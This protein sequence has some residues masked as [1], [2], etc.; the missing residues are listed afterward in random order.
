MKLLYLIMLTLAVTGCGGR[1]YQLPP[2]PDE[3]ERTHAQLDPTVEEL[4][5]LE[6]FNEA[7]RTV[8][9]LYAALQDSNGA[10]AWEL[11]SNE[12]R[13]LLDEWS[14]GQGDQALISGS[15]VRDGQAYSFDPLELFLLL[16]PVAFEDD[17]AGEQ[18]SETARRK[19]IF[20]VDAAD[21]ARRVVVIMEADQW[22]VHMPRVDLDYLTPQDASP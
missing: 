2:V 6:R 20:L 11:L 4:Q 8:L 7:R 22:R 1:T 9:A 15:L 21:R 12:T 18:Q 10:Q 16:D 5:E 13:L 19:E 14:D 17:M 3:A